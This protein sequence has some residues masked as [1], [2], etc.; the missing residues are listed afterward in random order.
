[1]QIY[2]LSFSYLY[3]I[4]I[5]S[6]TAILISQ[7]Y[8]SEY[9]DRIMLNQVQKAICLTR[10]ERETETETEKIYRTLPLLADLPKKG[11]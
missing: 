3:F 5:P 1:M 4:I 11:L 10:E 8:K 7:Y 2:V 6:S 9:Y